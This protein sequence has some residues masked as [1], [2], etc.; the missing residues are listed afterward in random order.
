MGHYAFHTAS[1]VHFGI[2]CIF[3]YGIIAYHV[4]AVA[5][6]SRMWAGDD[7]IDIYF[8]SRPASVT[9]KRTLRLIGLFIPCWFTRLHNLLMKLP[10]TR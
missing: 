7:K 10:D 2:V 1:V 6:L 9:V 8:L 3:A 5:S 4:L